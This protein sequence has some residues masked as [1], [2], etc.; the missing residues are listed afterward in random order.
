MIEQ[1]FNFTDFTVKEMTDFLE[2]R[3]ENLE[4][5]QENRNSSAAAKKFNNKKVTTK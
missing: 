2:T 1:G 4:P 3:V 5:N